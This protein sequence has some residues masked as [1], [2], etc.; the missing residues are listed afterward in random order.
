VTTLF[1]QTR[2][3]LS[4]IYHLPLRFSMLVDNLHHPP[5]PAAPSASKLKVESPMEKK[6]LA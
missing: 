4:H 1:N 3:S 5:A 6:V 2:K